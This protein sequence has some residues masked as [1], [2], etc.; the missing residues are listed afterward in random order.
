MKIRP[1]QSGDTQAL[2]RI[3]KKQGFEYQRP[4]L[5]DPSFLSKLIGEQNG[6]AS[7]AILA[8]LTA[9]AYFLIDPDFGT[10]LEKWEAFKELHEAA[11]LDCYAR[12]LDD[13]YCYLPPV[14]ER[15]FG[16]RLLRLGWERNKW[17]SFNR[18]LR[19]PTMDAKEKLCESVT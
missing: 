10:P 4:D 16:R 7:V 2:E 1:Y 13:I 11:R 17:M 15:P 14:I 19:V 12:G 18:L 9:E 3:F 6:V 5:G 8:R